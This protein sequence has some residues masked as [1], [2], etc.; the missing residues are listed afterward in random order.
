MEPGTGNQETA[1]QGFLRSSPRTFG[2]HTGVIPTLGARGEVSGAIRAWV[3]FVC[4]LVHQSFCLTHG[5][6]QGPG[7]PLSAGKMLSPPPWAWQLRAVA[8]SHGD[9]VLGDIRQRLQSLLVVLNGVGRGSPDVE[10][11]DVTKF[12]AVPRLPPKQR[13]LCPHR[14]TE[15]LEEWDSGR[16]C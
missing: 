5:Q 6:L 12:C 9:S 15:V 11:G 14:S 13:L 7:L 1:A 8:P 2:H 4:S 10:A 16:T 3:G